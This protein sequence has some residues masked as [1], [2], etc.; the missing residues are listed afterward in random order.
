MDDRRWFL[1]AENLEQLG[2]SVGFERVPR[3]FGQLSRITR[4]GCLADLDHHAGA[5]I[6]ASDLPQ[7]ATGVDARALVPAEVGADLPADYVRR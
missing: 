4:P 2:S 1:L 5:L 6:T 3:V 7:P